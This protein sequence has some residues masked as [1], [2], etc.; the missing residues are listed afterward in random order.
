MNCWE[1]KQCGREQG[2]FNAKELG[3]CPAYPSHG[4]HCARV[5]GTLCSGKVAG[6][7]S[8]KLGS[9]MSCDFYRSHNYDR[10]YG[11]VAVLAGV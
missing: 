1:F 4:K 2:G 10:S 11:K 3:V 8:T 9:C 6:T 5:T 7:F